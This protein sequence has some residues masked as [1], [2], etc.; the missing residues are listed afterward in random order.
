MSSVVL[1]TTESGDLYRFLIVGAII[2]LVV[3]VGPFLISQIGGLRTIL[4]G[5]DKK[6][7]EKTLYASIP[8]LREIARLHSDENVGKVAHQFLEKW[9]NEIEPSLKHMSYENRMNKI[10]SL[11][12]SI[13][14][15]LEHSNK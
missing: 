5:I 6:S 12:K 14:P 7:H 13:I 10:R 8:K 11:Y 3:F 15:I 2:L 4:N 9:D 1:S